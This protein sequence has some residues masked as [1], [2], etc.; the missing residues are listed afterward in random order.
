MFPMSLSGLLKGVN[1]SLDLL[2]SKCLD[3]VAF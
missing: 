2:L 3:L 1:I